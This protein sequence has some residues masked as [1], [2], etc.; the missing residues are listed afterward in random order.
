MRLK[1]AFVIVATVSLMFLGSRAAFSQDAVPQETSSDMS[2]GGAVPMSST[3]Q[4]PETQWVWGE[5]VAVDLQN[6]SVTVKY[7]DYE[8]DQEKEMGISYDDKT[9]FENITSIEELKPKDTVS[10]D[11]MILDGKNVAKNISIEKPEMQ[12]EP[13]A[14]TKATDDTVPVEIPVEEQPQEPSAPGN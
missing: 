14:E 11:Y 10:V 1:I 6:S 5:V 8:S 2:E 4:E 12:Q 7:L 9:A 3:D 13:S